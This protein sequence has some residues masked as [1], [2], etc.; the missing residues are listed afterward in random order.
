MSEKVLWKYVLYCLNNK[1]YCLNTSTKHPNCQES[2]YVYLK[3]E[4]QYLLLVHSYKTTSSTYFQHS[5]SN[6]LYS[7]I[8]L[9]FLLFLIPPLII[10][11][12]FSISFYTQ[13][14]HTQKVLSLSISLSISFSL[15]G[16]FF[17]LHLCFRLMIFFIL[18][19]GT[20]LWVDVI[21]LCF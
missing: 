11:L 9:Y 4:E 15:F 5:L 8:F 10:N 21:K 20:L 7:F 18:L 12:Q 6:F 19:F 13:F 14:S 17:F 3:A 16:A 1:N 2:S